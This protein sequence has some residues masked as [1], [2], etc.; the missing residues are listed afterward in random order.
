MALVY[1]CLIV[2]GGGFNARFLVPSVTAAVALVAVGTND[3]SSLAILGAW[4]VGCTMAA[5]R[6]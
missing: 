4:I 6:G 3:A 2:I 5:I 1:L